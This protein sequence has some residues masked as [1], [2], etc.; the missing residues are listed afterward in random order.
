MNTINKF[1][2]VLKD[3][4]RASETLTVPCCLELIEYSEHELAGFLAN[5]FQPK[6]V[7]DSDQR[8]SPT[9]AATSL[10]VLLFFLRNIKREAAACTV[11]ASRRSDRLPF[12]SALVKS[13]KRQMSECIFCFLDLEQT[14]D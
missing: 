14:D 13:C 6:Q 12:S 9:E 8:L 2:D 1:D 10:Q 11:L 7:V 4:G 5:P 3:K